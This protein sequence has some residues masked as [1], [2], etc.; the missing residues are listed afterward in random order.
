MTLSGAD[1]GL[2]L[3]TTRSAI[4]RGNFSASLRLVSKHELQHEVA[5]S[6][7][8]FTFDKV[9]MVKSIR[10]SYAP[11]IGTHVDVFLVEG[12][13]ALRSLIAY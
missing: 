2:T 13:E 4:L 7:R 10:V 1:L 6:H 11:R 8:R 5:T 12:L 3:V 9:F